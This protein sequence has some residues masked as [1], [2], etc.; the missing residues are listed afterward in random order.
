MAPFAALCK[1][2][3]TW[4]VLISHDV[5]LSS[6][7]ILCDYPPIVPE[8]I[9]EFPDDSPTDEML[10]LRVHATEGEVP[11]P[12]QV[13]D[14]TDLWTNDRNTPEIET[15]SDLFNACTPLR[16]VLTQGRELRAGDSVRIRPTEQPAIVDSRLAGKIATIESIEEDGEGRVLLGLIFVAEADKS[17]GWPPQAGDRFFFSLDEIEV[18][19]ESA[20]T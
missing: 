17:A 4:P 6:P 20:V 11:T 1:N 18:L 2:I 8:S 12:H 10:A 13:D 19:E 9:S 15:H 7:V 16:N 3:G 5:M 14:I